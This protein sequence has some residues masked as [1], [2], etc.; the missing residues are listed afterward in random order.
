MKIYGV[1][2]VK[3][4]SNRFPNKNFYK[5]KGKPMYQ[6]AVDTLL[7]SKYIK[8]VYIASDSDI[9]F[10]EYLLSSDIKLI[11][12]NV[13]ISLDDQPIYE[14]LKYCFYCMPKCDIICCVLANTVGH[15]LEVINNAIERMMNN[16]LKEVRSFDLEGLHNGII[17]LKTEIFHCK[18]ELSNGLGAVLSS[19]KEIHYEE[20]LYTK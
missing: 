16:N 6:H 17:V 4:N 2:L 14:V 19:G 11:E 15:T 5:V 13:N 7:N 8:T 12:R 9:P 20:E 1:V 10:R 18:H 3:E